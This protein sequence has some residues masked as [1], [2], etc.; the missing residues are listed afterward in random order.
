LIAFSL[1]GNE[2]VV[3]LSFACNFLVTGVSVF[4]APVV[5][6]DQQACQDCT[7]ENGENDQQLQESV[8]IR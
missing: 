2:G 7:S 4:A 3:P 6:L 1:D 5:V 8:P